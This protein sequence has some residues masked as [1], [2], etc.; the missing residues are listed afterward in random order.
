M[1]ARVVQAVAGEES[2]KGKRHARFAPVQTHVRCFAT[3]SLGAGLAVLFTPGQ[4][5]SLETIRTIML[6]PGDSSGSK[7]PCA[8]LRLKFRRKLESRGPWVILG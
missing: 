2:V 7:R 6:E 8:S 1:E 3:L 4:D 5:L